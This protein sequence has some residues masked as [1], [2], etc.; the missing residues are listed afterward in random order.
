MQSLVQTFKAPEKRPVRS[1]K[2]P[3]FARAVPTIPARQLFNK[4]M[5]PGTKLVMPFNQTAVQVNW[6]K[7]I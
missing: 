6:R 1:D 3:S 2:R 7:V 5:N 4:Q